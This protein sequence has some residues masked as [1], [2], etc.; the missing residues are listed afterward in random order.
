MFKP[1]NLLL[2]LSKA[3]LS[4]AHV[5]RWYKTLSMHFKHKTNSLLFL[6]IC[7]KVQVCIKQLQVATTPSNIVFINQMQILAVYYTEQFAIVS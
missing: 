4:L 1:I 3:A 2:L 5:T 6:V 7:T